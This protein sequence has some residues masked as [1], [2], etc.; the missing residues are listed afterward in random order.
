MLLRCRHPQ[1][2]YA[3]VLYWNLTSLWCHLHFGPCLSQ[4][5][6]PDLKGALCPLP[7]D[8]NVCVW[9]AGFKPRANRQTAGVSVNSVVSCAPHTS[10]MSSPFIRHEVLWRGQ[11]CKGKERVME[12]T[13]SGSRERLKHRFWVSLVLRMRENSWRRVPC[14]KDKGKAFNMFWK[15]NDKR[16]EERNYSHGWGEGS[17]LN[18]R[19]AAFWLSRTEQINLEDG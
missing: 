2:I 3:P 4:S 17:K 6:F 15:V 7:S 19:R 5:T 1:W 14:L 10:G 11:N 8:I 13:L 9:L 16:V 12:R 18:N